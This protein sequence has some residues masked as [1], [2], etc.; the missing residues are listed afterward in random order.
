MIPARTGLPEIGGSSTLGQFPLLEARSTIASVNTEVADD[1]I[2]YQLGNREQTQYA[3][4]NTPIG[5]GDQCDRVVLSDIHV[6]Q[7]D[8]SGED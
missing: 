2:W 1:W 5:E 4:F 3:S 7:T 8:S 6:S